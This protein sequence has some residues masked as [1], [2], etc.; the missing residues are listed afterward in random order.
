MQK[1][2][3]IHFFPEWIIWIGAGILSLGILIT[4]P[5]LWMMMHPSD[6]SS[7]LTK[8]K[9][10]KKITTNP[11]AF[12]LSLNRASLNLSIPDLQQVMSFS[13][14]PPR[15]EAK[16]QSQALLIRIKRGGESRK[17]MLPCRL[18]LE[19]QGDHLTFAKKSSLFWV[20]LA[21]IE[22]KVNAKAFVADLD[23]TA[24]E[25][26]N[27]LISV[28]DRPVQ[29][30]SEFAEGSPFRTLAEAH[31]WGRD[32]FPGAG[33]NMERLQIGSADLIFL[34]AGE[35]L[36]YK[37]G[38]WTK[39]SESEKQAPIAR[40]QSTAAKELILEGWDTHGYTRFAIPLDLGPPFK[41]KAEELLGS[42]RVRSEK[43][44]SCLLEKQCMVLKVGDWVLKIGGRW[45]VL[46]KKDE[47][48]AFLNG[49]LFG[50]LFILEQIS[51]KQGQKMI[52]GRLY[53]PNRTQ[54][55]PVEM[56][57]HSSRKPKGS[58]KGRAP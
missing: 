42:I 23:G 20:E 13:L 27:F 24:L 43:Q 57:A 4:L 33:V 32:L 16:E 46:R 8:G 47:Q 12:N 53:N 19:F 31:W 56:V 3:K 21:S 39:A 35:W 30:A 28:E 44:I 2:T 14:D 18:D 55:V 25:A 10:E 15:P 58:I 26:G 40:I 34:Q 38:K 54:I 45:K 6:S 17:V 50:E 7:L 52:Q 41:I 36:I 29:K 51:Q 48:D 1:L 5:F 49:K 9:K 37:G 11:L 22:G